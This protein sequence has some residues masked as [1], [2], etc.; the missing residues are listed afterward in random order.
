MRREASLIRWSGGLGE[1]VF[2]LFGVQLVEEK[3][4]V[5][6]QLDRN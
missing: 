2:V 6:N 3:V 1:L 5:V 4:S